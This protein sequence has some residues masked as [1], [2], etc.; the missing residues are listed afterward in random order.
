MNGRERVERLGTALPR[1]LM[2]PDRRS[3]STAGHSV[4]HAHLEHC[5]DIEVLDYIDA[6]LQMSARI[7]ERSGAEPVEEPHSLGGE[8]NRIFEEEGV[9]YRWADGRI[10]RFDGEITH[11]EAI[12]PA[13]VA[14]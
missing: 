14:L 2:L 11:R 8:I 6:V 1:S 9:G 4:S 5:P 3:R 7:I 12:L 13:L 10:V